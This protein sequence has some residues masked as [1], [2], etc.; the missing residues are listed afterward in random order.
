LAIIGLRNVGGADVTRAAEEIDRIR[1]RVRGGRTGSSRIT[2][3]AGD[4]QELNAAGNV[5]RI[6][7]G[8]V[9]IVAVEIKLA[10]RPG[11]LKSGEFHVLPFEAHLKS[12]LAENLRDVIGELES[13]GDFIRGQEGIAAESLQAAD[14]ESR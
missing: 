4:Q 3:S 1:S 13:R 7:G 14:S 11:W 9:R 2:R 8:N 12:V 5:A 6:F 10:A